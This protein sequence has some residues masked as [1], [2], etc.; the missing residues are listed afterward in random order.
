MFRSRRSNATAANRYP[1]SWRSPARTEGCTRAICRRSISDAPAA[2]CACHQCRLHRCNIAGDHDEKLSRADAA[3][4]QQLNIACLQH[5][6]LDHESGRHAGKLDKSDR[7][8]FRHLFGS[9]RPASRSSCL[10]FYASITT[11]SL[12]TVTTPS[13]LAWIRAPSL[14]ASGTASRS[15]LAPGHRTSLPEPL[16]RL[17]AASTAR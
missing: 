15:P 10:A 14:P 5:R 9:F 17:R 7:V 8:D 6:V 1:Q 3:R 16:A 12:F 13:I 4:H 2:A 11:A